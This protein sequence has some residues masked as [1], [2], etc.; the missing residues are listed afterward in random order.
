MRR[1][2]KYIMTVL[3]LCFKTFNSYFLTDIYKDINDKGNCLLYFKKH[4]ILT[5]H[6]SKKYIASGISWSKISL[7]LYIDIPSN[8]RK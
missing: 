1:K 2:K 4:C 3:K 5:Q 6:F 7:L 8:F